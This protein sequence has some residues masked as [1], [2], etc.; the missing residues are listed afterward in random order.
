MFIKCDGR[1]RLYIS[2]T[3]EIRPDCKKKLSHGDRVR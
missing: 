2:T 3:G 1:Y